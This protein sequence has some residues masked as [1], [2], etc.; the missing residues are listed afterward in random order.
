M[1]WVLDASL[2]LAWALPDETSIQAER[3]LNR[4]TAKDVLWVPSLWWVEI[5]NALIVAERRK[6]LTE[7]DGTR[8]K[9]LY[10]DLPM[11]TDV[12]SGPDFIERLHHLAKAYTLSAYDAAYLELA[13]RRGLGLATT[14]LHLRSASQKAGVKT[15]PTI[16]KD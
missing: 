16:K 5:A 4:L 6:R 1:E 11:K 13:L 9:K 8:L 2:A 7:A 14:D 3:F 10:G 15:F 12:L